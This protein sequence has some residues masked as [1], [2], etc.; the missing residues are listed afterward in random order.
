LQLAIHVA[1]ERKV[2]VQKRAKDSHLMMC[3]CVDGPAPASIWHDGS[4]LLFRVRHSSKDLQYVGPVTLQHF[5]V[6][7][8]NNTELRL[9]R[10]GFLAVQL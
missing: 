10:V 2:K 6:Y 4:V 9:R 7:T 3:G 8:P 1:E 5:L